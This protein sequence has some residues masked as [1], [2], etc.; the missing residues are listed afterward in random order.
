MIKV[1]GLVKKYKVGSGEVGAVQGVDFEVKRGKFFTLLGPSGCG[2][3]TTLRCVAGLEKPNEG[4]IEIDGKVVSSPSRRIFVPPHDR[5]IGMVFQSYAIWPH[6]DVFS[7]VAFPLIHGKRRTPRREVKERVEKALAL[8]KLQGL[9]RRPAPMLSGGQQQ[10]LALARAI[11]QEPKVL[12]LDEPLSNLDAKLRA[13]MRFEL[14]GLVKRLGITTLYVTH[15]QMEALTMSDEV[16]VMQGGVI[17][18]SSSPRDLYTRPQNPFVA[19][20]VGTANFFPG[21]IV[22]EVG[23]D[24]LVPV[25]IGCAVFRCLLSGGESSGQE[26]IVSV[27]PEHFSLLSKGPPEKSNVLEGRVV[28]VLFIGEALDCQIEVAEKIVRAR[29]PASTAVSEGESVYLSASPEDCVI[30][31]P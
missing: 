20:F 24:H 27:R 1:S 2:K 5:D 8:V 6:M 16:A 28:D 11:V 30:I 19:S 4:D 23:L 25:N 7:N 3:T 22:G 12:L 15:D 14:R 17:V 9:E 21:R 26:V 13:E 18:Q 29:V 31:K 10:R